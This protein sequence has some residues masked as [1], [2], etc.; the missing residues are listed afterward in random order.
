MSF[1]IGQ[2]IQCDHTDWDGTIYLGNDIAF[3]PKCNG[4]GEYYDLVWNLTNGDIRPV[5]NL[6][7][8]E[9]LTVKSVMTVKGENPFHPMYGTSIVKSVGSPLASPQAVTR[10]IEQEVTE[11]LAAM[12]QRQ[13]QQMA[14]GQYMSKDEV[15]YSISQLNVT[16]IDARTM[17][18]TMGVVAE[19]GRTL[20]VST[21]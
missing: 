21:K 11:A 9:E 7:L 20:T 13:N 4:A 10:L 2:T 5:T 14:V 6:P 12:R 15:I 8:L 19:S 3:C 16:M 18:V 17:R 1:D